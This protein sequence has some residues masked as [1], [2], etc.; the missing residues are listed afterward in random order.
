MPRKAPERIYKSTC[1]SH[2][3][4]IVA[5]PSVHGQVILADKN[6]EYLSLV[7]RLDN[8]LLD[9]ARTDLV[10]RGVSSKEVK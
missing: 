4:M 9:P 8:G 7:S 10:S 2:D 1:G 5:G 6:G 3:D